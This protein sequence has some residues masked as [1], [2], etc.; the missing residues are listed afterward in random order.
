VFFALSK[1]LD[2]LVAPLTWSLALGAAALL[3]RGRAPRRATALGVAALAILGLCSLQPVSQ[4]LVRLAEAG[5]QATVDPGVTYDAVI[6]LGGM[7]D[8]PATRASG[9]LELT[10]EADRIVTALLLL[11]TGR[12][13]SVLLSGGLA[14]ARPGDRSEADWL[15]TLLRADG[16]ADDRIVVEGRSKNTREN[17]VESARIVAEHGWTRL[18]LVTSAWHA[19]RALGCFRAVG[20]A[21]DLLAVDRRTGDGRSPTWLPRAVY[22]EASTEVLREL[23]GRVV[24]RVMGYAR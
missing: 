20:L 21:P 8:P 14:D 23:A 15:A 6:V 9:T 3:L 11:R 13:R 18:L 1:V 4:R 12:A 10:A 7:I 2:L 19:P 5:T 17:A 16:I 24:Y 22:L